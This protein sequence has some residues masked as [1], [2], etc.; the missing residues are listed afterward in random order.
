MAEKKVT[1]TRLVFTMI[2]YFIKLITCDVD[3]SSYLINEVCG[4]AEFIGSKLFDFITKNS[5]NKSTNRLFI[6]ISIDDDRL[7]TVAECKNL[8][9]IVLDNF[10]KS[11]WEDDILNMI[12]AYEPET[13]IK[14]FSKS[15]Y[16]QIVNHIIL[17]FNIPGDSS[18]EFIIS[19]NKLSKNLIERDEDGDVVEY[20]AKLN[21]N[22]HYFDEKRKRS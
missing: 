13:I 2:E 22:I 10:E 14:L 16:P 17:V 5:K 7:K 12:E 18:I 9:Y 21:R 4:K 1:T 6:A 15:K 19:T 20:H 3:I 11:F 8:L